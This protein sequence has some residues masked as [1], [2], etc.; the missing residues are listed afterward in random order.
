MDLR[1]YPSIVPKARSSKLNSHSCSRTSNDGLN[2]YD[3]TSTEY[4]HVVAVQT[5]GKLGR[6]GAPLLAY[7]RI[8]NFPA[9]ACDTR[10]R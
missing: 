7:G 9:K 3:T 10:Y 4:V 6:S 5:S 2:D 8:M 1:I